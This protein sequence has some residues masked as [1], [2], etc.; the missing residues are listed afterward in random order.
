M[1]VFSINKNKSFNDILLIVKLLMLG[2]LLPYLSACSKE[3]EILPSYIGGTYLCDEITY[4]K[5]YVPP[6]SF[7][8]STMDTS[9]ILTI[10]YAN[11]MT[12]SI[13]FLGNYCT[14]DKTNTY[15]WYYR[16][17]G[18]YTSDSLHFEG[19]NLYFSRVATSG[20]SYYNTTLTG[21]LI[22]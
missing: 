17:G 16:S 2:I 15:T 11:R 6:S 3:S 19:T 5:I 21:K 8:Y 9:Y 14:L 12:N 4:S 13:Y 1:K 18:G 7:A 22:N 20:A 10:E